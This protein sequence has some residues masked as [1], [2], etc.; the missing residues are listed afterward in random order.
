MD[1]DAATQSAEEV[2]GQVDEHGVAA[3][4]DEPEEAARRWPEQAEEL[5]GAHLLVADHEPGQI[6]G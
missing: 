1:L 3:G 4:D 5:L 2:D 6:L